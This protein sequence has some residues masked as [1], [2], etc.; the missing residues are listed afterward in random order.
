MLLL[1]SPQP[2]HWFLER[3]PSLLSPPS[4]HSF[5][6]PGTTASSVGSMPQQLIQ[7]LILVTFCYRM[8][9]FFSSKSLFPQLESKLFESRQPVRI[10]PYPYLYPSLQ[11]LL[12]EFSLRIEED[13][14]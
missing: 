9:L 3:P 6:Q 7:P 4:A 14:N 12:G 13:R 11:S 2:F 1:T 10:R 8:Y 5:L